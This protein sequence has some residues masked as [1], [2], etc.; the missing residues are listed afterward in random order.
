[1]REVRLTDLDRTIFASCP[2]CNR[3]GFGVVMAKLYSM[4]YSRKQWNRDPKPR[5]ENCDGEMEFKHEVK[6][7]D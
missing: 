2:Q 1:M 4:A 3:D 7:D 5:C 6:I